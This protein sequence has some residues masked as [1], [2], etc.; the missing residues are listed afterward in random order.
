MPSSTELKDFILD[1]LRGLK[2]I[3]CRKMMGE[4]LLYNNGVLFGGIY[5]DRLLLKS[6]KT[7]HKFGLKQ[8]IPYTGARPI[9]MVENLEDV[10]YLENL[11]NKTVAGL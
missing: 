4:Y 3:T 6:T 5:G 8:E 10:N 7:N 1:Q 2:S 11:I 9:L